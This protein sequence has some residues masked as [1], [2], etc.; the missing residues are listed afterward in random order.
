MTGST[1][2]D[3]D[4][5]RLEHDGITYRPF[6]AGEHAQ[7]VELQ[8]TVWDPA[9]ATP[10]HQLIAAESCGGVLIG[11]FVG[12]GRERCVGFTYGFPAHHRGETWL[13]SHQTAVESALRDRN[14]GETLKWLQ[15]REAL[16][17]GYRRVTWTFDPLQCRNAYVNLHKLGA[18]SAAYKENY[19]GELPDGMNIGLPSDR[20]WIDWHL[21]AERVIHRLDDFVA[22][23]GVPLLPSPTRSDTDARPEPPASAVVFETEPEAHGI[24][25]PTGE[26]RLDL[27]ADAIH[28]EAP[29]DLDRLRDE[30][31]DDAALEWRSRQRTAFTAYFD[32]GYV[33][34]GFLT[35]IGGRGRRGWYVLRRE[36]TADDL[37]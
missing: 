24:R 13:H 8:R 37:A 3:L 4:G 7:A 20:L 28:I 5:A 9:M 34:T 16:H 19:Y 27:D 2:T 26:T 1:A 29:S 32:R 36:W 10:I 33:A 14:V 18:T 35:R 22:R 17:L 25:V 21:D 6:A 15:R 23:T 31:G 30:I 11:A 12:Q